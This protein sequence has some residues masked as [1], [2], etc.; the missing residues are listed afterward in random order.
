MRI[1]R[2]LLA[3]VPFVLVA[4]TA[5]APPPDS[6]AVA[7]EGSAVEV[8]VE[9]GTGVE[10]ENGTAYGEPIGEATVVELTELVANTDAYS[11]QRVRVSGMVTGVCAKRGCWINIGAEEGPQEVTFK[12]VD[13]VIVFPMSAQGKWVEAEGTVQKIELDLEKSR[14]YLAHKAE[15]GG[16]EFDPATVTAP[17]TLVRLSGI[18]AVVTDE[19]PAPTS[20]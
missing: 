20:E 14:S 17:I 11:G 10:T 8:A 2:T 18:G 15:E 5:E 6:G 13:G 9:P 7:P 3:I 4:C 19:R 12:V 16:E 1:T